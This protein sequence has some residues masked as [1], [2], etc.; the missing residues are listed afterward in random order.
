MLIAL[1]RFWFSSLQLSSFHCTLT[2]LFLADRSGTQPQGS[3]CCSDAL[4]VIIWV[5]VAFLGAPTNPALRIW[6]LSS[7]RRFC[8]QHCCSLDVFWYCWKWTL[9]TA[10]VCQDPVRSAVPEMLQPTIMS[11]WRSLRSHGFL[12]WCLTWTLTPDLILC[13]AIRQCGQFLTCGEEGDSSAQRLKCKN[14]HRTQNTYRE[15]A[16]E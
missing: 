10:A 14:S 16:A 2:F 13:I 1:I 3:V 9:Q 7:T 4:S 5:I 12:I 15:L 8:L 11:Q 6:P